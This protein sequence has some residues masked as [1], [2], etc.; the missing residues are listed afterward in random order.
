MNSEKRVALITAG[1]ALLSG[2]LSG[3]LLIGIAFAITTLF[4]VRKN[5]TGV[6]ICAVLLAILSWPS[7]FAI[8]FWILVIVWQ[9]RK[10]NGKVFFLLIVGDL[11]MTLLT[12]SMCI[13]RGYMSI[14]I[15]ILQGVGAVANCF[16]MYMFARFYMQEDFVRVEGVKYGWD[17]F[18]EEASGY[19][20]LD[21]YKKNM[22]K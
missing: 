16:A 9:Y 15:I 8:A 19:T 11:L 18:H 10:F 22:K 12:L 13:V 6:L 5:K 20:Y 7:F 3:K 14:P 2:V 1:V 4:V 17:F 21:E